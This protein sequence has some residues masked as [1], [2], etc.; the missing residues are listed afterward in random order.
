[1]FHLFSEELENKPATFA[2][3][4]C[5][6]STLVSSH[7]LDIQS[8]V[9]EVSQTLPD[10]NA[11]HYGLTSQS[12][13]LNQKDSY[14]NERPLT[15]VDL[16]S[17]VDSR[18]IKNSAPPCPDRSLKPVCDLVN[19][20][21]S[22]N[23]QQASSQED[24]KE[25]DVPEKET[26]EELLVD[27]D[28]PVVSCPEDFTK[29]NHGELPKHDSEINSNSFS[30][31]DVIIPAF[32]DP[33]GSTSITSLECKQTESSC[34]EE[35][36]FSEQNNSPCNPMNEEN[37]SN[38][39]P[40]ATDEDIS[41]EQAVSLQPDSKDAQLSEDPEDVAGSPSSEKE[42]SLSCLPMAVSMCGSLVASLDPQKAAVIETKDEAELEINSA[43]QEAEELILP[44]EEPITPFSSSRPDSS[45][46]DEPELVQI[47]SNPERA[48][49]VSGHYPERNFKRTFS[50]TD[51]LTCRDLC[52]S[53]PSPPYSESP[54]YSYEFGIANDY[55]P[56]SDQTV[57]MVTD[58]ELDAFLMGQGVKI[59]SDTGAEKFADD[60]FSEFNG[61]VEG[62]GF[63]DEELQSCK[64]E[65]FAS[66]ESDGSL[67]Y[68]EE[69]EGSNVSS[70]S[71]DSSPLRTDPT[72]TISHENTTSPVEIQSAS[73]PNQETNYGGA[74]PKQLSNQTVRP[75]SER[76]RSSHAEADVENGSQVSPNRD[77]NNCEP[78]PYQQYEA[79]YGHDELSEPP[80]YPGET[81]EDR[82]SSVDPADHEA[83]GLGSKQPPWVPDSEAPNCMNCMQ[84]FTFTKRRHH[85][86]ACG[87]VSLLSLSMSAKCMYAHQ[88]ATFLESNTE[89]H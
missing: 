77:E 34:P 16:L 65:T 51:K 48:S 25:L 46:E 23:L 22:A 68:L 7:H 29:S 17:S 6:D 81:L 27:F 67:Q 73:S 44:L 13:T 75:P 84:K 72:Q 33:H 35:S 52:E 71:Q 1:M 3:P 78:P 26:N 47:M 9:P 36:S 54:N 38:S 10:V 62:D 85:C 59:D 31:L 64:V 2:S 12:I 87:K 74:R 14:S 21:G 88:A 60:G 11:L 4:P 69:S 24:F 43:I 89:I 40:S 50:P 80:P 30:L 32:S 20:T 15:G 42:S 55:L 57:M 19:D 76:H 79:S 86:R 41:D 83:E 39:V 45:P 58:E 8:F 70:S 5:P 56:E 82:E 18:G 66:P 63:L 28:S 37:V 49:A 53:N 61:N